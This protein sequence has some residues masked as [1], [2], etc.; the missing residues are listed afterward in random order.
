MA[1][2]VHI[3]RA[4]DKGAPLVFL[5]GWTMTG[6]I[7]APAFDRLRDRFRCLAPDLPGHGRTT[8][9][10]VSVEGAADLLAD[11]L[12]AEKLEGAIVVGWSLGALVGWDQLARHG[13]E[14]VA[15]MVSIDMSP[16]PLP[17]PGW[18]Y[19]LIGQS[20]EA[21]R[22]K[23]D[24]FRTDWPTAAGTIARTMFA[25][26][27]GAPGLSVDQARARIAAT[28]AE[29]MTT[30]WDSLVSCDLRA[31]VEK[32]PVPLLAIHGAESRVYPPETAHWLAENT[33]RGRGL[34]LPG[35]GHAPILEQ[36]DACC[37]AIATFALNPETP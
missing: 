28:R 5:H 19:G 1:R 15:G 11:L 13:A 2:V 17:A 6:A 23:A 26:A 32:L 36:P 18:P 34:V 37:D 8:G 9:Y 27:G 14:R 7:F 3:E 10:A 21:A 24:W 20:A 33:P 29:A 31:A 35:A 12:A 16:R 30:F 4:G 25:S 22:A